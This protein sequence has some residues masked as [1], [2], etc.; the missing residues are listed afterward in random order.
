MEA[1]GLNEIR[2]KFLDFFA[3][4]SHLVQPSYPLVPQSDK[5]LLLINA[6][7]VPLKD[8]FTGAVKPPAPRLASCQKCIR[9]NDIENVGVTSRHASFFEMLGNFSFGDYFKKE[10]IK[11][12]WNFVNDELKLDRDKLWVTVYL[13]DEEAL[14]IWHRQEGVPLNRIV[15]LGKDDNFWEI[16]T[17]TGPCGP[18]SEIYYDRGAAFGCGSDSCQPGCDCDRFVEFWNLVFTQ[19]EQSADGSYT[20]LEKPNIDTGMGLERIACIVQ[21]VDSI[22]DIDVMVA[23][24]DRIAHLAN[25]Q[26]GVDAQTDIS[27]RKI[28]DHIRAIVFLVTDGVVPNNEGRGYVLRRLLRRAA[29][30]G[31]KIGIKDNFLHDLAD[32]V[33]DIFG[34][35]YPDLVARQDYTKKI[36]KIEEE[37]FMQTIDQGL[38]ILDGYIADLTAAGQVQLSGD[39]AFK[40]YD[41]YG[42]PLDLTLEI[43]SDKQLTVDRAGFERAMAAQ[44]ERA[45]SARDSS[46]LGWSDGGT[47][48]LADDKT[49]FCGYSAVEGQ[50]KVLAL[51]VDGVAQSTVTA[52]CDLLVVLDSTPF[53]AESGGQVGDVGQISGTTAQLTVVDTQKSQAGTIMHHC[54]INDGQIDVGDTVTAKVDDVKRLATA[55]NHTATHLLHQALKD[56]L[57]DHVEQ[58][59]S[60]VDS[61]RLRFDFRHFNPLSDAE[62]ARVESIVNQKVLASLAVT[63]AEM[64]I[65]E[66]KQRGAMALFGEK[67]GDIVRVVSAADYSIELCGGTH[68]TNTAQIGLFKI[69]SETGV[70]AGIRR[71]EAISGAAAQQLFK[72]QSDLLSELEKLLKTA[73]DG[74]VQKVAKLIDDNKT[75][76]R[77]LDKSKQAAAN[78][79]LSQLQESAQMIGEVNLISGQFSDQQADALRNLADQLV[80]VAR[81]TLVVLANQ[82][83]DKVNFIAMANDAAVAAGVHCG[84]IVKQLAKTCGGGGGGRP[85]MAQAGGKDASK[86]KVALQQL[87]DLL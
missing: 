1:L 52:P 37:R 54:K 7:M 76:H 68:L 75:L 14:N 26:Y 62:I 3:R 69:T 47:I 84:N 70:A 36:I 12:A 81:P 20:P 19:F 22:F 31:K 55:R 82:Q 80:A 4:N 59:G 28:T 10:A 46:A 51:L 45:R 66:A 33:I 42:F 57:G 30:H 67:Y 58:S 2:K 38:V 73:Q 85:N 17:G 50:A 39:L 34:A 61:K 9:T 5:T 56:V 77:A 40:L 44:R 48:E 13:E 87:A 29:R 60:L 35:A 72:A 6:G 74:L 86:I 79:A 64:P 18:C 78:D 41:T 65:D 71:I 21:G 8:F 63:T 49:D 23:I 24:R 32:V 16:G 11:L 43:L 53:Y 15:K 25:C 27:I 83:G